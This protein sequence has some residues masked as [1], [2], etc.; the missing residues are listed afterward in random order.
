MRKELKV[1]PGQ[2]TQ[3]RMFP[4]LKVLFRDRE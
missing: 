3:Q 4:V 2:G 1:K